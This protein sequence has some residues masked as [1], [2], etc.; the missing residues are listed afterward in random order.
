MGEGNRWFSGGGGILRGFLEADNVV[1]GKVGKDEGDGSLTLDVL[2]EDFEAR[3]WEVR[4]HCDI[5]DG[6]WPPSL[7][8]S[9][10]ARVAAS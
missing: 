4:D 1:G 2:G 9:K 6:F 10:R 5:S 3:S 8:G 7:A